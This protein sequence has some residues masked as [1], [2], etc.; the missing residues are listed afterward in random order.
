[1]FDRRLD[2]VPKD[3]ISKDIVPEDIPLVPKGTNRAEDLRED[4]ELFEI[5]EVRRPGYD[6][7][8]PH[9]PAHKGEPKKMPEIPLDPVNRVYGEPSPDIAVPPEAYR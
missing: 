2:R 4:L 7:M 8:D 5:Y 3:I 6:Y 1:M 9:A